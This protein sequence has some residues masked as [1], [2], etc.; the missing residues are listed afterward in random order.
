M[1][2]LA[3][4][5]YFDQAQEPDPESR[6][7]YWATRYTDTHKVFSFMPDDIFANAEVDKWGNPINLND[8]CTT[9]S[10]PETSKPENIIGRSPSQVTRI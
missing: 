10:C 4:H 7:L 8:Y 1:L 3:T 5:L 9:Y 2:P 6:G